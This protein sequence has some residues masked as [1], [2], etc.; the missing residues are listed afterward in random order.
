MSRPTVYL[1]RH[2]KKP[3]HGGTGLSADGV[4]RAQCLRHVVGADSEYE[5]DYI[6]AQRPRAS[7]QHEAQKRQNACGSYNQGVDGR[8]ARPYETMIPLASDLG[9]SVDT[10]CKRNEYKYVKNIVDRY[11]RTGNI[12]ICWEYRRMT[13]TVEELGSKDAPNYPHDR[14]DIIWTDPSPYHEI[15]SIYSENCPAWIRS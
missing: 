1:V 14:F 13:H 4:K 7:M 15:T 5:I 10:S 6:V 3:M 8:R 11:N 9:L 12:L 2:G